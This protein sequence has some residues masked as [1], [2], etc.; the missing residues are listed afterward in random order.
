MTTKLCLLLLFTV[1]CLT[2][3]T[4]NAQK[5]SSFKNKFEISG[6]YTLQRPFISQG[7]PQFFITAKTYRWRSAINVGINYHIFN[8]L[9]T[10]YQLGFSQQ[11]GGFSSQYTNLNYLKNTILLGYNSKPTNRVIFELSTGVS[12]NH[13]ISANYYEK[14]IKQNAKYYFA[15]NSRG[16]PI[17]MGIKTRIK[18]N[19]F[20][21]INSMFEFGTTPASKN[22]YPEKISIISPALK[23]SVSKFI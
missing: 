8:R 17:N 18:P 13:L 11:G 19:L 15:T 12:F 6:A 5:I 7:E 1:M 22:T 4:V 10:A 14:E 2:T 21:G 9:F 16:L 23:L 3:F 20:L